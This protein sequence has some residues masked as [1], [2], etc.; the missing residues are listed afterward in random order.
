MEENK[1][2]NRYVDLSRKTANLTSFNINTEFLQVSEM[3][4]DFFSRYA[5]S[6]RV[7]GASNVGANVSFHLQNS[8]RKIEV[9]TKVVILW[10]IQDFL[11]SV[12]LFHQWWQI[13]INYTKKGWRCLKL[14][15]TGKWI[16]SKW[17]LEQPR[18]STTLSPSTFSVFKILSSRYR[19]MKTI[20]RAFH[21]PNHA[22]HCN[23]QSR[24]SQANWTQ[25][26]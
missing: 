8:R 4:I 10:L 5:D 26:Y 17:P 7:L 9:V 16:R 24:T 2:E 20:D 25:N 22:A 12:S 13:V 1:K 11:K 14:A 6:E 3:K 21:I 19:K 23:P 18:H 15:R